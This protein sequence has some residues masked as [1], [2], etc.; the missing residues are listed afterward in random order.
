MSIWKKLLEWD[1]VKC[2]GCKRPL[3]MRRRSS[4]LTLA[5]DLNRTAYK[6]R[7]CGALVCMSCAE[8]A[9]CKKC[10]GRVFDAAFR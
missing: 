9:P 5:E 2:K 1:A 7:S 4:G 8:S 6:C 3:D 10:G